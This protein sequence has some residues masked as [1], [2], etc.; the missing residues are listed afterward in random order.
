METTAIKGNEQY[1]ARVEK[2]GF[3][4][5]FIQRYLQWCDQQMTYRYVWFFAPALLLPCAFMPVAVYAILTYG[6]IGFLPFLFVSMLLF[7]GG[8]VANVGGLTTRVTIN[9]FWVAIIWNIVF[10]MISLWLG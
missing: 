9:L 10:P 1:I 5:N 6:G 3:N 4:L 8:I 2:Q 7:I